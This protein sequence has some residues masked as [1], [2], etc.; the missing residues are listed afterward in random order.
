VPGSFVGAKGGDT[1]EAWDNQRM[2]PR[3]T[4]SLALIAGVALLC[5]PSRAKADAPIAQG[6]A[7]LLH[8]RYDAAREMF[9]RAPAESATVAAIGIARC[10]SAV[11]E[12]DDAR[13]ILR[14]AIE[15][16]RRSAAAHASWPSWSSSVATTARRGR[17]VDSALAIDTDHPAA[18]YWSAELFRVTGKLDEANEGYRWLVRYYNNQQDHLDDPEVLH[19][20]GLAGAQYARWN[21]NSSQFHFL[22]NT[23]YP[24]IIARDSTWW[25]AHLDE[26]LL[27]I[28]KYNHP[29]AASE[30][31][32]ALAINRA[33]AEAHAA[34]ALLRLRQFDLDSARVSAERALAINPRLV[35]AHQVLADVRLLTAGPRAALTELE[36]ARAIDP[37][38]E[39]TLGQ[40]AAALGVVDG[41]RDDPAGTRYG[42]VIDEAVRRNEHC[43][44][45]FR[46]DGRAARPA[47]QVPLRRALLRRGAPPHAAARVGARRARARLHAA[48]R[49]AARGFDVDRRGRRRPVQRA[50]GE[51]A[52]GARGARRLRFARHAPLRRA[53]RSR[54]RQPARARVVALPRG[55]GLPRGREGDGLRAA[56]RSLFEIFNSTRGSSGHEW[57]SVRMAGLPFVGTV[58]ACT[59]RMVAVTSPNDRGMRFSWTRVMKH[60]FV[61]VLNLQQTDFNIP[62]W[63]TEGLAVRYEGPGHPRQWDYVLAQRADSLFDLG[64]STSASSARRAA[65]TGRWRTTRRCSTSS[66]WRRPTARARRPS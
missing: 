11:G 9:K 30:L 21:R 36:T 47:R 50:R 63:F 12:Y 33:A 38:D 1:H 29:D 4:S 19:W 46:G 15:H 56:G 65:P 28:E 64:R 43:G 55:A 62:R 34:R 27:F 57:F 5:A 60:E 59:G 41:L 54:A 37:A 52:P 17:T 35:G 39:E 51:L 6:R 49:R 23:L 22:V 14:G 16:D 24:D 25:R 66:T 26:A 18:R 58:G 20:I 32:A 44:A 45:F 13:R 7:L 42:A 3:G 53:L 61:H 10:R 2:L 31:D 48:R 40:I 8:G